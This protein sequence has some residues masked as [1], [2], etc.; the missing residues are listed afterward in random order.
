MGFSAGAEL[1]MASA[2]QYPEFNTKNNA[3]NDV[4]G[5]A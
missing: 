1:T 2:I 4:L 3:S 5:A